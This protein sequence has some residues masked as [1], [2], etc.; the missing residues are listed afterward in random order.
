M[1][2]LIKKIKAEEWLILNSENRIAQELIHNNHLK[3]SY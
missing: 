2:F 1:K 3:R